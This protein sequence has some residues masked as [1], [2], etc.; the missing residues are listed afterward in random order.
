MHPLLTFIAGLLTFIAPCTLPVL[1][2]FL[3]FVTQPAK[4][5]RVAR[6]L[7]F[8]TGLAM[9]FLI[10]GLLAGSLGSILATHKTLIARTTGLLLLLLGGML[11]L[12]KE[13]PGF[14]FSQKFSGTWSGAMAFG[15]MFALSWTGCIGPVLG[16]A[17]VLAANTQTAAQGGLLLL[18]YAAGLMLPLLLLALG[19]DHLPREGKL[20]RLLR[21]KLLRFGNWEIHSTALISGSMLILLG[22]VFLFGIDAWLKTSPMIGWIFVI[23]ER[24]ASWFGIAF[25]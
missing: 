23:E 20:W 16:A 15:T 9:V 2:A 1:P 21:G 4:L 6:T 25:S 8:G 7:A 3:A 22:L 17:L 11:L 12:G 13:I 5:G 10:Y 19:M 14:R 18:T 24:I